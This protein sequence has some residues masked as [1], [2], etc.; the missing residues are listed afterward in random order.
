MLVRILRG[1]LSGKVV[2]YHGEKLDGTPVV[3]CEGEEITIPACDMQTLNTSHVRPVR[4][5]NERRGID[6]AISQGIK[7]RGKRSRKGLPNDYN[8]CFAKTFD[9]RSWKSRS[10]ARKSWA[11]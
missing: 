2:T 4:H 6:T 9:D 1:P 8:D 7:V 5:A 3:Y 10:K 11:A